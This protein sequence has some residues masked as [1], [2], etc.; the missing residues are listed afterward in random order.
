[1]DEIRKLNEAKINS[2]FVN[3]TKLH[4]SLK[5]RTFRNGFVQEIKIDF[6]VFRDEI[7]GIEPIFFLELYNVEPTM[8]R[9]R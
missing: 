8:E 7:N 6:F 4:L 9:E 3:G 5:D 2:A 1:M